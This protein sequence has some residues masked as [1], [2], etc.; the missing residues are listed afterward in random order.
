VATGP[1]KK[2]HSKKALVVILVVSA[3]VLVL[4]AALYYLMVYRKR[5]EF[6]DVAALVSDQRGYENN[7]YD[8][9]SGK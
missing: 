6:M 4:G 3:V 1:K 5:A 7:E 9:F 8:A 2:S